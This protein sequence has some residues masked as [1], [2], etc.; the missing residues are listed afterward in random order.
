MFENDTHCY[1]EIVQQPALWQKVYRQ[2]LSEKEAL[3]GFLKNRLTP[4]SEIIFTGA[5]SSFFTGEMVAG[6][7]QQQTGY[8]SK[9]VSSTEIVTYPEHSIHRNRPVLLVSFARSGNSP[10]S[11]A[12]A[13]LAQM[14]NPRVSHLIITCNRNGKLSNETYLENKYT[15]LLPEESNDKALAMTS[16]VTSMTLAALLVAHINDLEAQKSQ[17][18]AAA[19]FASIIIDNYSEGIRKV[20]RQPFERAVFL[21]SGPFFGTAHEAHLKVQEMTDG[22]LICKYDSFLGFRHGPKAVINDNTLMVY[23]H[24]NNHYVKQYE[25]DLVY[26]VNN[27][28]NP[29]F[30]IGICAECEFPGNY[31]F[32]IKNDN[33]EPM[34]EAYLMLPYLVPV[35]LFSYFKSSNYG[36][37]PD[38]PSKS[39]AIHRVVQG[40]HI[41][42]Y[43]RLTK[44]EKI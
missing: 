15:L 29:A 20:A 22:Q 2:I 41:Y 12:A 19:A 35:Q 9:A 11:V 18:E 21:G 42:E 36:L 37:N 5:G 3:A 43:N 4:E 8:P 24:S 7:F 10:E 34:N 33:H 27:E 16:S 14:L 13:K 28:Q 39:G 17:V 23:F 40:V 6:Y 38:N 26:A 30:S 32:V 1:R 25:N 31:D 44:A